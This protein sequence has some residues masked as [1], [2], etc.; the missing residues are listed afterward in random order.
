MRG[1]E[2]V[3]PLAEEE[4]EVGKRQVDRGTTRV[5]R[6]VVE[7]PVEREVTLHGERVKVERR[8][9]TTVARSASGQF[10]ECE[11]ETHE[12]AE[13]P[14]VQK[15]AQ[16]AEEVVIRREEVDVTPDPASKKPR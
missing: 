11:V 1:Q 3:I 7:T 9:P 2:E 13:V 4:V 10:E 5:R 16:V 14:V 8:S 6:Y 12:T 15:T